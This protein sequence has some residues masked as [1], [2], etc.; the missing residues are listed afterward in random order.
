[1]VEKVKAY[2]RRNISKEMCEIMDKQ[3][4][5]VN[6]FAWNALRISDVEASKMIARKYKSSGLDK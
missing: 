3:K 4:E 1:M 2:E 5:K 6:E